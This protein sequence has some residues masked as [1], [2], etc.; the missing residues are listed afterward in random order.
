MFTGSYP[1]TIDEKG[2]FAIPAR[3][4]AE[5]MTEAQGQLS[6][7]RIGSRLKLYPQPVFEALATKILND[8]SNFADR[9]VMLNR[10]VGSS[11]RLDMDAQ[12]RL[13]VPADLRERITGDA[14]LVG[15]V[16]R[17]MLISAADWAAYQAESEAQFLAAAA[18]HGL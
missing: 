12:G 8:A 10:F 16:D 6:I 13:L 14:V 18:A 7:S 11:M 15:Q 17:F 2:R 9:D 1:V 4:R 3:F 5:L